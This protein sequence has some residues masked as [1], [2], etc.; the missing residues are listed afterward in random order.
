MKSPSRHDS[1]ALFRQLSQV[2]EPGAVHTLIENHDAALHNEQILM[3]LSTMTLARMGC[4]PRDAQI[5]A[6]IAKQRAALRPLVMNLSQSQLQA[7]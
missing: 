6:R 7:G 4:K 1:Q 5:A 3:R 2:P